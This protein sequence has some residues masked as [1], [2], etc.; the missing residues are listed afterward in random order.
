MHGQQN[1]K[2]NTKFVYITFCARKREC[3][4]YIKRL[5]IALR[6][7]QCLVNISTIPHFEICRAV[8]FFCYVPLCYDSILHTNCNSQNI[9]V[10]RKQSLRVYDSD[11]F[12]LN[13]GHSKFTILKTHKKEG[14]WSPRKYYRMTWNS[15]S[16]SIYFVCSEFLAEN[17]DK[18]P[19]Y[20]V[21][22]TSTI[23][24]VQLEHTDVEGD[25]AAWDVDIDHTFTPRCD[26]SGVVLVVATITG[27]LLEHSAA[28]FEL[29]HS[30]SKFIVCVAGC[31]CRIQ[32]CI[33]II[34][35]IIII[36]T[37]YHACSDTCLRVE[38]TNLQYF[39]KSVKTKCY[40]QYIEIKIWPNS[41]QIWLA[42]I[43]ELPPFRET[44]ETRVTHWQR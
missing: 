28:H 35:I 37:S 5:I 12:R 43:V 10:F 26:G 32:I 4:P 2:K 24:Q 14:D 42:A 31:R 39:K 38:E 13:I 1:T 11:M 9:T 23:T 15:N 41:H 40:P 6:S 8:T 36:E 27:M 33:I 16:E 34:I 3:N 20:C 17:N 30:K 44:S 18:E 22:C 21:Y 25:A 29:Y 7:E 19:S